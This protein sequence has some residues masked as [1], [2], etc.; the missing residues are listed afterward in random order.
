MKI[1]KNLKEARKGLK[2]PGGQAASVDKWGGNESYSWDKRGGYADNVMQK[3]RDSLRKARWTMSDHKGFVVPDGSFVRG[4][5]YW[6]KGG[7]VVAVSETY[8]GIK[9]DNW[10]GI[11]LKKAKTIVDPIAKS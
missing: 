7:W 5:N 1:F 10:F 8:G 3:L 11:S 9:W 4:T 6:T 2:L